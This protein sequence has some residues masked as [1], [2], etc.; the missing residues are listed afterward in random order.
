MSEHNANDITRLE[1]LIDDFVGQNEA[2]YRRVFGTMLK[3]PGYKFTLN[4]AAALLGPV[5]FGARGLWNWFLGVLILETAAYIQIGMGLFGDLGAAERNRA[6]SIQA[7]LDLR[8]QQIEAAQNAGN[9]AAVDNLTR[10]AESLEGA[11]VAAQEAAS[12]ADA[13]G[14]WFIGGGLLALA[15]I[16]FGIAALSNW[17]LE[18]QF[19]R[20]RS[21]RSVANG[22][23]M[24]RAIVAAILFVAS[25]I[26]SS[27]QFA[28]PTAFATLAEFPTDGNW[29]LAVGDWIQDGFD[30]LRTSGR[31]VFD[32]I[33]A[34]MRNLLDAIEVVLVDTPWPVVAFVIIMLAFLSAGPRVAIF[35]GVALA[36]LGL[37]DFWEKAMTT[38]A[39]LGAAALI[40]ITL[41][42]PFGIY[43]ARRPRAF[44]IVRPILDFMQSMPSFVYLIPVVAFIGSGKPAGVVA[45]MIFG[46]PP[47][48]RFTVLGLQQ[49][50]ETIREAALA[51]G[52][53]PRY[54][55]W[56]VELPLAAKTIMA[57][58]NQT[59]LLSLAMVVVASL[60]GAQGLGEDVLEALQFAAAGQGLLAGL[61][62]LFCALILDRIV[63]GRG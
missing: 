60:I 18:Q 46:S 42:I 52:A 12:A 16:K 2:Y 43:C 58:V 62:I 31:G 39:L 26:L 51:F 23:S 30:W 8:Y 50:P 29:R 7:T 15:I 49:V 3:A 1:P 10:A 56:R 59:I 53:T 20:W 5:W 47:V 24:Q 4:W 36:Y 40:S 54:L 37:L 61:A 63:A 22:W 14:L 25:V 13:T 33:T 11:L 17:T 44:A 41:G 48:I 38:V 45:T 19:A 27:I 57:G 6:D 55:L 32:T 21:D 28:Q 35:T 9:Q 34:G